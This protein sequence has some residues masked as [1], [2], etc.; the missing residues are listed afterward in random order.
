MKRPFDVVFALAGLIMAGPLLAAAMAWIWLSDRHSPL[1]ASQRI[2]K[3]SRPFRLMK[4]RSMVVNADATGVA[5]TSAADTRITR[6]GRIVRRYKLDELPQLWNVLMGDMSM[7]GPRPNVAALGT[8][9]Y[10]A[11]E[12]KLLSVKPGITDLASIVFADEGDILH[13]HPHPDRAYDELIRPWKS[14]L[15]LLYV[16]HRSPWLDMRL[17]G[18]TV[19]ALLS[20]RRALQG[21]QR[22]LTALGAEENLRRVAT[23]QEPLMPHAPP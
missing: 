18:L 13:G 6:P 16:E 23:R 4:L 12:M 21:V 10:T 1:Y 20:R 9:L 5:S 7:V 19:L 3:D 11:A 22:V 17:I 2:G 14:R 8:E 15:G